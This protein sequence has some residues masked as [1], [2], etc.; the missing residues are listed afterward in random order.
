MDGNGRMGRFLMNLTTASGA[1]PWNI[2]PLER[3]KDYLSALE[4]ASVPGDIK[5]FAR[6]LAELPG[7]GAKTKR[8]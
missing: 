4:R 1:Y 7:G 2:V 6:F 8:T 5:P 3:C